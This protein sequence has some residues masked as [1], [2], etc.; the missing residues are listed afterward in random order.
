MKS[1]KKIEPQITEEVETEITL[2]PKKKSEHEDVEEQITLPKKKKKPQVVEEAA[3]EVT[4]KKE[5]GLILT[6]KLTKFILFTY[7]DLE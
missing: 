7:R 5:V 2:K 1:K 4:I 6:Q 3:A